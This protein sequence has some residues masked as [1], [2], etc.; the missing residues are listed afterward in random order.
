M[1]WFAAAGAALA[2]FLLVT[3]SAGQRLTS[4][5]RGYLVEPEVDDNPE[6]PGFTADLSFIPSVVVGALI[7]LLVAQGDLF[8]SDAGRSAPA[9]GLLGG[10]AGWF[11]W[12]MRRTNQAERRAMR[13]RHELPVV[14]DMIALHAIAGESVASAIAAVAAETSGVMADELNSALE[15]HRAG[16]GLAEAL[17]IARSATAHPDA[18]R[19]YE[20]L[21]HAHGSGGRLAGAMS[22]LAVDFRAGIANDLTSEGGKRAITS[23][24]PVLVLMVPTSLLF[25]LYPTL[26]GLR[27]LSGAP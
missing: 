9:L 17:S 1:T 24:G 8:L 26:L 20:A 21:I 22:D 5:V 18:Q 19:L 6:A 23:Y 11:V 16:L 12:S 15:A 27:A 3:H 13:L 10:A 4:V 25:L 7:G 2:V 14:A